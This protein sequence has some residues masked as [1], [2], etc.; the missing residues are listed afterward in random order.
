MTKRYPGEVI[1]ARWT[2]DS[3]RVRD[4]TQRVHGRYGDSP[5]RPID[6]LRAC[7]EGS[8]SG[9]EVV[10]RDDAVFV[11]QWCLAFEYNV[12]SQIHLESEWVLFVMEWGAYDIPVPVPSDQAE[13]ARIVRYYTQQGEEENRQY[14]EARQRPT[15]S[16][17]LLN[18][19]E[20][21]FAWVLLGLFF[22]VL[23]L[24]VLLLSLLHGG[25]H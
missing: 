11:G 6:L 15:W 3:A 9:L 25:R 20:A 5:F 24:F 10:C 18:I 8:Q 21:R 13:A 2:V 17:R 14:L 7:E 12:V 1:V 23:P 4:F 19:A 22:I 16:N